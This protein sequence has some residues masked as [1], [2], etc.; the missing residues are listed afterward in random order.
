MKKSTRTI[1]TVVFLLFLRPAPRA[2]QLP[3]H[4]Q[5]MANG[6]LLNPALVGIDDLT[7]IKTSYRKQ[8]VG[9]PDS[10]T[11]FYLTAHQPISTNNRRQRRKQTPRFAQTILTNDAYDLPNHFGIGATL[12]SD[13]TGPNARLTFN[14][15]VGYHATLSNNLNLSVGIAVGATQY[16]LNFD[17]IKLANPQD[18]A[19]VQGKANIWKPDFQSGVMLHNPNFYVGVSVHQVAGGSLIYQTKTTSQNKLSAHYFVTAGY[20]FS[21][22][23]RLVLLPSVALKW[24]S[25]APFAV[26]INLR[27]NYDGRFWGGVSYR[28]RAA[29]VVM[30]GLSLNKLINFSY[31]YDVPKSALG[32]SHEVVLGITLNN[33]SKVVYPH[34][35]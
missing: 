10:P 5:Y 26:D 1:L 29:V 3:Q 32:G 23:D 20:R 11:T 9:L 13:Q 14:T 12:I 22:T 6:F 17:Q 31:A 2:Q 35:W 18:P 27:A 34:F 30:A 24:V 7:D 19:V 16:S 28:H 33:R 15:A 21:L 25:P 4:S 8:W